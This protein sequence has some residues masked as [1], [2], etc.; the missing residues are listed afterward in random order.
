[1]HGSGSD[2]STAERARDAAGRRR[3][4][5][6]DRRGIF[7][8]RSRRRGRGVGLAGG[9]AG[10]LGLG[11]T[12]AENVGEGLGGLGQVRGGGAL[13]LPGTA[14]D[15]S[16]GRVVCNLYVSILVLVFTGGVA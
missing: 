8:L 15:A 16:R 12:R 1:M 6:L 3:G 14:E 5:V 11:R 4:T 13:D 2:G 10:G 9:I 7:G